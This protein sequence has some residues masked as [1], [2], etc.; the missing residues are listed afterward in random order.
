VKNL[1]V[2][3]KLAISFGALLL[4]TVLV[5]V[6][7]YFGIE[8]QAHALAAY[9]QAAELSLYSSE[10]HSSLHQAQVVER[11][12]L[13]QQDPAR[14]EEHAKSLTTA[15]ALLDSL[16][17]ATASTEAARLIVEAQRQLDAYEKGFKA[18]VALQRDVGTEKTGAYGQF[19]DQAHSVETVVEETDN[20]ELRVALLKLRRHEK[21]YLMRQDETSLAAHGQALA[22]LRQLLGASEALTESERSFV[23]RSMQDYANGFD[24]M[25]AAQRRV[26]EKQGELRAT[27][28]QLEGALDKLEAQ[29]AKTQTA[30]RQQ[31]EDTRTTAVIAMVVGVLLMLLL[32]IA[33]S[34]Y[35]ARQLSTDINLLLSAAN[36]IARGDLSADVEVESKDEVGAL[37]A[38][39]REMV[40]SLRTTESETRAREW[41]SA[42]LAHINEVIRGEQDV[43][44]LASSAVADLARHS[45][46]QLG[47]LYTLT[48]G[49][50]PILSLRGS[51]AYTKRK[52]LSH[53]FRLGEGLVGQAALERE[54][55]LVRNVPE[56]YVKVTSG[57]G[58]ALPQFVCVTPL[59]YNDELRGVVEV[60]M[61]GEPTDL[62][63]DYLRQATS[64]L[65]VT[66]EMARS[67]ERLSEAL[68]QSQTLSEELQDQQEAL[69][70]ANEELEQ[71]T[72]A[73]QGS[74]EELKAQQ[75]ELRVVNEEL[76][77]RNKILTMQKREV[78]AAQAAI[79]IKAEELAQASKYK[80]EFLANM[81]HELRTP[82][83][84]LL[85]LSRSLTENNAGNLTADQLESATVI[86][87]SGTDLLTLINEILDLSKIE[88]GQMEV[89]FRSAELT[90]LV[91]ALY[92][93]L[94][95]VAADKGLMLS[96]ELADDAPKSLNTDSKRVMQILK[97]LVS[98][99]LKFTD[100]GSV[101]VRFARP[102]ATVDLWR[103][104]L[105][106]SGALAISVS[107]TG[108]GI[109]ADRQAV[110]F[111][112]F[113]QADGGT[114]RQYGGTGLGL[115]ISRELA[116]LLGGEIQLKS[117]PGKGSTFTLFLPLRGEEPSAEVSG[118][119]G[120]RGPDQP[121]DMVASPTKSLTAFTT[122]VADDRSGLTDEDRAMLIIEDDARFARELVKRC[123]DKGLKCVVAATGEEGLELAQQHRP[124]AV[125][126]DIRL[127]GMSGWHV[128]ERLK[129]DMRLRHIPVHVVSAEEPST[130]AFRK[131]AIGHIQKPV[132]SESLQGVF[133]KLEAATSSRVKHLLV[134]ED[135][136]ASR[137]AIVKL[138]GG[139]DVE[140]DE[141]SGAQEAIQAVLSK[142]YDCMILDLGL[143]DMDGEK[144]LAAIE[145]DAD[146]ELPPVIV[147]TGRE[148]SRE[149]ELRL[150]EYTESIILK[151]VRSE[152]RLLD[153][154]SL[155]LHRVVS[156]MPPPMQRLLVNLHD[157]DAML[158]GKK[159]LIADDDMRSAFALS[160]VLNGHGMATLKAPDG[161]KALELLDQEPD[162]D[163]VLMDIMMPVLDGYETI[164][165]IR[166]Q[167]RF[168]KLP[169]IA[170]TA[171]AMKG[172][173]EKC[174][175]A[176]AND[177]LNKPVDAQRLLSM[178]RVW[179]YG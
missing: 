4:L 84:S 32:G 12:F 29:F 128:L 120:A 49:E 112:A 153:E 47:A 82:L 56:D 52:Q 164:R 48:G 114:A 113:Q 97:N 104:G 13:L 179:L 149:Q 117:T 108:I 121:K 133:D 71:Q 78:E 176:G 75:E 24:R 27:S 162:V 41:L 143:W 105:S 168:A 156:Q 163:L 86:Y 142:R 34:L 109:P 170:V 150:R 73:L 65:A 100:E 131:G 145:N 96:V 39:F 118:G 166:S 45:E 22:S 16:E 137:K 1:R 72:R 111:E 173:M 67:R 59:L 135:D 5:G 64:V 62:Q 123:H 116:R 171:K 31:A 33:L 43:E 19:R 23:T 172:D 115:S 91:E 127:P 136:D 177:Y 130:L 99:A 44:K 144:L 74:E 53:R 148:V 132:T 11:D 25:V 81:S 102:E 8:S 69:R 151:D 50:E 26:G 154:V 103:S 40:A 46:A 21:D 54:Q 159:I 68:K 146:A 20:N 88:A 138:V 119:A 175:A 85:L 155:F 134:V 89:H 55:L 63:L 76:E 90:E 60:G 94:S 10:V 139:Q 160:R 129:S 167:E 2:A 98:N 169:I 124:N 14:L 42:G 141:A 36:R 95:P 7:A 77:E 70:A 61:L 28:R 35:I 122:Q 66:I 161:K 107:D 38:A 147:Y 58:D 57:L 17:A 158:A 126:L 178:M 6:A 92:A 30:T 152:E 140:V 83:N 9:A 110:I 87:D 101:T 165:R 125:I 15:H 51:Y 80:S 37:A 3:V 174:L 106:P 18:V 93:S 79:A 157:S